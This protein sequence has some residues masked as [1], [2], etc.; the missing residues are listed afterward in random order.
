M[1]VPPEGLTSERGS[2]NL[3]LQAGKIDHL[4]PLLT[5]PVGK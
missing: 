5:L 3:A 1:R 2:Y 4:V